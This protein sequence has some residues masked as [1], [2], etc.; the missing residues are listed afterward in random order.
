[1]L[2][3]PPLK[4]RQ[5]PQP[6]TTVPALWL[7]LPSL[8]LSTNSGEFAALSEAPTSLFGCCYS[9]EAFRAWW[10]PPSPAEAGQ[11][12]LFSI[13]WT[14]IML[15][16]SIGSH[17]KSVIGVALRA[18]NGS[19][20]THCGQTDEMF[21]LLPDLYSVR[22]FTA[23]TWLYVA[24]SII[25]GLAGSLSNLE[26]PAPFFLFFT[27]TRRGKQSARERHFLK[28]TKC[29]GLR[30]ALGDW[31][32][33]EGIT[34][35]RTGFRLSVFGTVKVSW[36]GFHTRLRAPE[37]AKLAHSPLPVQPTATRL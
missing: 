29:F 34:L 18:Q 3:I 12:S 28:E 10:V 4:A 11:C 31:S 13:M 24:R 36:S 14:P 25:A 22:E 7:W 19:N 37:E 1:M 26:T 32:A 8:L 6:S 21:V 16:G 9:T 2:F 27:R 5:H 17:W 23:A 15:W 33:L 20:G 35:N 30:L